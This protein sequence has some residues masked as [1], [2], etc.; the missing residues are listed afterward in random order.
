MREGSFLRRLRFLP[1]ILFVIFQAVLY[2]SAHYHIIDGRTIFH[3]HPWTEANHNHSAEEM[4]TIDFLSHFFADE[5]S[6]SFE[7]S[8]SFYYPP[9]MDEVEITSPIYMISIRDAKPRDPPI[10]FV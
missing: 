5:M 3:S 4:A 2:S 1:L 10:C 7:F 9:S 6:E 8:Q